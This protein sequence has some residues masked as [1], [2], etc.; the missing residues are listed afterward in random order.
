MEMQSNYSRGTRAFQAIWEAENG[1]KL[2]SIFDDGFAFHNLDGRHDVT[3]LKGLRL[4]VAA[5]RAAYPGAHLRVENT[6]ASGSHIAFDW[7]LR[8]AGADGSR[9]GRRTSASNIRDGSCM[10]R[11]NGDCVVELWE[12]NGALAA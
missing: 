5:L 12:L 7:S 3:D 9:A 4:R 6:V 8:E 11:L 10:V 2:R 1:D